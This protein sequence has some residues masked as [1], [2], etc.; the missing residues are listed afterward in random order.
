MSTVLVTERLNFEW[1]PQALIALGVLLGVSLLG[2]V[3]MSALLSSGLTSIL[4]VNVLTS[5]P[6]ILGL[7]W[8]DIDSGKAFSRLS[9]IRVSQAGQSVAS[10]F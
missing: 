7:I 8:G 10:C 6:F 9:G 4:T 1:L 2:E 3:V 5:L